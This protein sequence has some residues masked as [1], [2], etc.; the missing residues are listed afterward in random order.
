[1]ENLYEK[2]RLVVTKENKD[3]IPYSVTSLKFEIRRRGICFAKAG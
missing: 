3:I 1:M 2:Y